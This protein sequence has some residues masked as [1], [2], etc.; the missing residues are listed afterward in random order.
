[1]KRIF[2]LRTFVVVSLLLFLATSFENI[3]WWRPNGE[4][5]ADPSSYAQHV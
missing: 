4:D 2:S 3:K 5:D 1:M